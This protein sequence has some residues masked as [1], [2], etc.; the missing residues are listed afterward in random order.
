M[1]KFHSFLG[2]IAKYTTCGPKNLGCGVYNT[3]P[4]TIVIGIN[5]FATKNYREACFIRA[6]NFYTTQCL[7]WAKKKKIETY[8][9]DSIADDV[10]RVPVESFISLIVVGN[11]VST[12]YT[13]KRKAIGRERLTICH[14]TRLIGPRIKLPCQI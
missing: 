3:E 1:L 2:A 4:V 13:S 5:G 8:T 11:P 9:I 6:G 12:K 7:S 14:Q 10:E